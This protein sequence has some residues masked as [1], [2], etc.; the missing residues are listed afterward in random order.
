M[1]EAKKKGDLAK[2]L[3]IATYISAASTVCTGV[4]I[5]IFFVALFNILGNY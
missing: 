5:I 1:A 2:W 3:G 4:A